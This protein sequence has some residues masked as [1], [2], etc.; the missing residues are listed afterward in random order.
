MATYLGTHGS[1]IQNYT[2]DPDNPN[3]GEVWYNAT[4]KTLKFQYPAVTTSGSWRTGGTLNTAR[5]Y[6][7]GAGASSEAFITFGNYPRQAIT[8]LWNGSSWTEVNDLNENKGLISGAGTYTAAIT[9]G[10]NADPGK[11]LNTEIWNG[12]NWTEVN[13]L[14]TAVSR[15]VNHGITTSALSSGGE[16]PGGVTVN[17][18]S[19]NGTNW[20]EVN[21]MNTA[22]QLNSGVGADNTSAIAVGNFD[23]SPASG[24]A[25]AKT[26]SWNGTNWTEVADLNT[27]REN[28]GSAGIQTS[29]LAIGGANPSNSGLSIGNTE[30]ESSLFLSFLHFSN[31]TLSFSSLS[32]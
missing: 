10:G 19:W 25:M 6:Q 7:A 2:T 12:T 29:A 4:A 18:N 15:N 21:D 28:M 1:R 9:S 27:G 3:T 16:E 32:H 17:T 23:P 24:P 20:T 22:T 13:N 11:S 30:L 26:E 8:E 31:S 14:P 5:K